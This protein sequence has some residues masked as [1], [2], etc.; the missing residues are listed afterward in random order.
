M[1][2]QAGGNVTVSGITFRNGNAGGI[3][4]G[5]GLWVSGGGG[6]TT[7]AISD[8][9]FE[10]NT[11][12]PGPP[13]G[14]AS[15]SDET[16]TI[17]NSMFM[18]NSSG[19]MGGGL[20]VQGT[21]TISNSTFTN[22]GGAGA[23][24][25]GG[26]EFT[27][28]LL[29]VTDSTFTG[30]TVASGGQG[31]AINTNSGGVTVSGSTFTG[32]KGDAACGPPGPAMGAALL[33]TSF[34]GGVSISESTFTDNGFPCGANQ[35]SA[36]T[37]F[38][39]TGNETHHVTLVNNI[40]RNNTSP[41]PLGPSNQTGAILVQSGRA[42]VNVTNNT[43]SGNDSGDP[44]GADIL[45]MVGD[46]QNTSA[47]NIYNNIFWGGAAEDVLTVND[48]SA[49]VSIP[50]RIFNN[51]IDMT[52]TTVTTGSDFTSGGNL[53]VD[54]LFVDMA[55]GD[56]HITETSP[57]KD[58]GLNTAPEIPATDIDGDAR[59]LDGTVDMGADEFKAAVVPPPEPTPATFDP[60]T[61]ILHIPEVQ[62]KATKA[63]DVELI[64]L[65]ESGYVFELSIFKKTAP[66]A[67]PTATFSTKT[68][69]LDI[70]VVQIKGQNRTWH[71]TMQ[72]RAGSFIFDLT[73]AKKN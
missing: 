69:V 66:T 47:A 16:V 23:F 70:L 4:P 39:M 28:N 36:L 55:G 25:G 38:N 29:T 20:N 45:F 10:N 34:S 48:D 65:N 60:G 6:G 44:A 14:G 46:S 71:V 56:L 24:S 58:V 51:D 26:L 49:S 18:G 64:R 7:T 37:I 61:G 62:L 40:F 41:T 59:I 3:V 72:K 13:G 63:Y 54:P 9:S 67:A 8:C 12:G 52:A 15:I 32:N 35:G 57:V 73:G 42:A 50:V 1:N 19:G 43:F 22:N 30:N 53:N 21:T 2:I 31:G 33:V 11:N 5:G 27:G 68:G 17:T